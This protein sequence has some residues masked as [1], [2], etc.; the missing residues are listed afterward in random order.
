M[1]LSHAD[2]MTER[3]IQRVLEEGLSETNAA[4]QAGR[5]TSSERACR[6]V[7]LADVQLATHAFAFDQGKLN[8]PMKPCRGS[9]GCCLNLPL[10]PRPTSLCRSIAAL[11]CRRQ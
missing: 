5:S 8:N 7:P 6:L 2:G 3:I 4:V 10:T 1:A 9:H 11:R